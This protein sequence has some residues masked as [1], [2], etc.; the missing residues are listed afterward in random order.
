MPGRRR[1]RARE[2]DSSDDS[3]PPTDLSSPDAYIWSS[4]R[5]RRRSP[6]ASI[7]SR[8]RSRR[9]R[10]PSDD[11]SSSDGPAIRWARRRSALEAGAAA[12]GG[13]P[14][15]PSRSSRDR[16]RLPRSPSVAATNAMAPPRRRRRQ[17][18]ILEP[19]P[20]GFRSRFRFSPPDPAFAYPR[21]PCLKQPRRGGANASATAP[22][23]EVGSWSYSSSSS[24]DPPS[25]R[26]RSESPDPYSMPDFARDLGAVQ[27]RDSVNCWRCWASGYKSCRCSRHLTMPPSSV[28][29][30]SSQ[31]QLSIGSNMLETHRRSSVSAS[32]YAF[33][34][35]P[36]KSD[37]GRS[38]YEDS[39]FYYNDPRELEWQGRSV[40]KEFKWKS[41]FADDYEF[42]EYPP[43][44]HRCR[45]TEEQGRRRRED[46]DEDRESRG[47][48]RTVQRLA[49]WRGSS[50]TCKEAATE[51]YSGSGWYRGESSHRR[52]RSRSPPPGDRT[53]LAERKAIRMT[54]RANACVKSIDAVTGKIKKAHK[55][56][57]ISVIEAGHFKE[58]PSTDEDAA[59]VTRIYIVGAMNEKGTGIQNNWS[60]EVK[61]NSTQ[62]FGDVIILTSLTQ[63]QLSPSLKDFVTGTPIMDEARLPEW[64][65]IVPMEVPW[66]EP[67]KEPSKE[68]ETN[69]RSMPTMTKSGRETLYKFCSYSHPNLLDLSANYLHGPSRKLIGA[70]EPSLFWWGKL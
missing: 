44:T 19:H 50:S 70:D 38:P 51:R 8:K 62:V 17:V 34:R 46:D 28:K 3:S 29:E 20:L 45:G 52:H 49:K 4:R 59:L 48:G 13:G 35:S 69:G 22:S 42:L 1:S 31:R 65:T 63:Q 41:G 15:G 61:A 54:W 53:C 23:A 55:Q 5:S 7:R 10:S 33:W 56:Q 66:M 6:A 43:P 25:S 57:A 68:K 2:S 24:Y 47:P 39:L 11:D 58:V 9:S 60:L 14:Y 12:W 16:P 37:H 32:G 21:R 40:N 18:R 36:V 30:R 27:F 64:I 26:S 67:I